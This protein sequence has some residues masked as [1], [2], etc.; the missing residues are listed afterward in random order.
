MHVFQ[1]Y[2]TYFQSGIVADNSNTT[3]AWWFDE[4]KQAPD[5]AV[6]LRDEDYIGKQQLG[7]PVARHTI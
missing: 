7:T 1:S 5:Y 3:P 2:P 4:L 6:I